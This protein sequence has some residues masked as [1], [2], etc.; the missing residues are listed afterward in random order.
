[1]VTGIVPRLVFL[2]G[3]GEEEGSPVCQTADY[4]AVGEN[5]CAGCVCDSGEE[6]LLVGRNGIWEGGFEL[7]KVTL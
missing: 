2:D 5:K 1:M 7:G 3:F 6:A 4:A